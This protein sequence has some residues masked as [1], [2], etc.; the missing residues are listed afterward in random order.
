MSSAPHSQ[1]IHSETV[2]LF[3]LHRKERAAL[4]TYAISWM[5]VVMLAFVCTL[6]QLLRCYLTRDA[7]C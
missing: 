2:P 5:D 6:N 4:R 3:D 1:L 7:S